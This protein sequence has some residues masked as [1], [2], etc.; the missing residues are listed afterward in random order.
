MNAIKR[1]FNKVNIIFSMIYGFLLSGLFVFSFMAMC[2]SAF[3]ADFSHLEFVFTKIM[4]YGLFFLLLGC[5]LCH[6]LF[7]RKKDFAG[8]KFA[9][10]KNFVFTTLFSVIFAVP[11]YLIWCLPV[12][13]VY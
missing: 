7:L 1:F 8:E 12:N 5:F 2:V 13:F 4:L 6:V 9:R 11:F 3:H 10:I